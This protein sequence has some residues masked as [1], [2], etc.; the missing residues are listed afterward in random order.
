MSELE[1]LLLTVGKSEEPLSEHGND[2]PQGGLEV[3][4]RGVFGKSPGLLHHHAEVVLC[5]AAHRQVC[6]VVDEL[7]LGNLSII[8]SLHAVEAVQEVVKDLL[9]GLGSRLE[10]LGLGNV[11]QVGNV[12]SRDYAR[13]ILIHELKR[14]I[15]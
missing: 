7:L 4:G 9:L 15:N 14:P 5:R 10:L 11:V 12:L 1:L 8:I 2:V 3:L 6:V 13:A